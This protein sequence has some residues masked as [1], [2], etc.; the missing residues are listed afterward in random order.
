MNAWL[1]DLHAWWSAGDALMPVMLAVATLLYLR[2]GER[3]WV[4]WGPSSRRCVRHHETTTLLRADHD[5]RQA[6]ALAT[7][8]AEELTKG[9]ATIAACTAALPLL[10]LLGTVGGMVDTF[11]S[12][13]ALGGRG[14]GATTAKAASGG[15][16]LALTATQYG[17]ALALPGVIA[18]CIL[19]GRA[20]QLAQERDRSAAGTRARLLALQPDNSSWGGGAA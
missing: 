7:S 14:D 10:G 19:G 9:L 18:G 5:G 6:A 11:A 4:L 13:A 16:G 1:Q 20:A 17:M 15:I 2:V 3:A 12:L 8:E